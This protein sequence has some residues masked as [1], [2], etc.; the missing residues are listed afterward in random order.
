LPNTVRRGCAKSLFAQRSKARLKPSG[1]NGAVAS[2]PKVAKSN[3]PSSAMRILLA[4]LARSHTRM[5][6]G[7]R[8]RLRRDRLCKE[9]NGASKPQANSERGRAKT[10]RQP[11]PLGSKLD[12]R[13]ELQRGTRTTCAWRPFKRGTRERKGA[14]STFPF[15]ANNIMWGKEGDASPK[16]G[17]SPGLPDLFTTVGERH[18]HSCR[19][20][21]PTD[22]LTVGRSEALE[23]CRRIW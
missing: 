18:G 3:P 2:Q 21:S 4:P 8:R 16:A 6:G 23:S 15:V 11:Q 20:G 1:A 17:I 22:A 10:G 7:R 9:L 19:K 14:S 5:T 13:P 12:R